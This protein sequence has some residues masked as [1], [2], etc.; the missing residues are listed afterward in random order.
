MT[1]TK[2]QSADVLRTS[3]AIQEDASAQGFDWPDISGVLQKI[4]EELQE[5]QTALDAG[6]REH[7]QSELGDLLFATVNLARFLDADPTEELRRATERFSSRFARLQ[8]ELNRES[9]VMQECSIEELDEVW[10]RVK[11]AESNG[12]RTG[13]H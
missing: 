3:W 8:H 6:D 5:I 12:G 2:S 4:H 13:E 11:R 1:C 7:A 9:R 10:E